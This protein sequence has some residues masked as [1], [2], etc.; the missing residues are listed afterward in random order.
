MLPRIKMERFQ[1]SAYHSREVQHAIKHCHVFV[2]DV[3]K[4]RSSQQLLSSK[5][6]CE[7]KVDKFA[8]VLSL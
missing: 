3:C 7:K 5:K 4:Q 8:E 6:I 2:F 1:I